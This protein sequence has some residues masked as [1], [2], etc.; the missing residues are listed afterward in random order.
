MAAALMVVLRSALARHWARRLKGQCL[1][2]QCWAMLMR[3][4]AAWCP[5]MPMPRR[6][7]VA[8]LAGVGPA[9]RP[10]TSSL[11][12]HPVV[13]NLEGFYSSLCNAAIVKRENLSYA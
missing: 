5:V 11:R 9:R 3:S 2:V 12:P 7:K 1:A 6:S 4:P 13:R 8:S 10:G